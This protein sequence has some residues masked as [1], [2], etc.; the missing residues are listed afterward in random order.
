[1]SH[2]PQRVS[3]ILQSQHP[4]RF[5]RLVG[6]YKK[7]LRMDQNQMDFP[8]VVIAPHGWQAFLGHL[9]QS[10]NLIWSNLDDCS[11]HRNTP[12]VSNED[13]QV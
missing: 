3:I 5:L 8:E 10:A 7:E 12:S 11:P 13:L 9:N 6:R 1:M 2:L 4:R